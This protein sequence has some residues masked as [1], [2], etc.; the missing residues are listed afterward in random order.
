MR[1]FRTIFAGSYCPTNSSFKFLP[2]VDVTSTPLELE[3]FLKPLTG[4][5]VNYYTTTTNLLILLMNQVDKE[6]NCG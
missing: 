1:F 2:T 6:V 3:K 4:T 5:Y